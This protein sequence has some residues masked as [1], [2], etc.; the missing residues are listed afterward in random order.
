MM[1]NSAEAIVKALFPIFL[2]REG[3]YF[4]DF[5]EVFFIYWYFKLNFFTI[6]W[7]NTLTINVNIIRIN[8]AY[9]REETWLPS[10]SPNWL[11]S[12]DEIVYEGAN[13]DQLKLFELPIIIV[14][15]IVSPIALPRASKTPPVIPEIAAGRMTLKIVVHLDAPIP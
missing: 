12:M 13:I 4:R 8:A 5:S 15:A 10:A 11:A 2:V 6:H 3:L 14:T 9:I 1:A 7:A